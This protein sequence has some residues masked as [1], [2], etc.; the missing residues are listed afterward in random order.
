M[1]WIGRPALGTGRVERRR[2][3][4]VRSDGH[5]RD[6]TTTGAPR[7]PPIRRTEVK[8]RK[9]AGEWDFGPLD[10]FLSFHLRRAQQVMSTNYGRAIADRP[11]PIGGVTVLS[12]IAANPGISQRELTEATGLNKSTLVPII[13]SFEHARWAERRS[14][15]VDRRRHELYATPAGETMLTQMFAVLRQVEDDAT[16]LMSPAAKRNLLATLASFAATVIDADNA[17]EPS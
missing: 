8:D 11:I 1:R 15:P 16:R 7:L 17:G 5:Q 10:S 13:D 12:A 2:R 3:A 9:P 14:S 6:G 4:G